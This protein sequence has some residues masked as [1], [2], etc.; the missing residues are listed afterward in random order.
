MDM[1]RNGENCAKKSTLTGW[2]VTK[3]SSYHYTKICISSWTSCES[4]LKF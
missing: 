2:I 1:L 4:D 3:K